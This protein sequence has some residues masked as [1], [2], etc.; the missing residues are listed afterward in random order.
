MK[1]EVYPKPVAMI[2]Y[3][4]ICWWHTNYIKAEQWQ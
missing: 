2:W 1:G 3:L 4:F